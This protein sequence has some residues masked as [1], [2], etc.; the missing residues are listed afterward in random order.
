[1]RKIFMA[2]SLC[3]AF[4][5]QAQKIPDARPYAKSITSEDLKKHLYTIA[6]PDYEGRETAT[7]GQHKVA[8]YI[9]NHFKSLGLQPGNGDPTPR[10]RFWSVT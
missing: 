6:G 4:A 2:A 5:A 9:E 3:F 1:M 8:D 10:T 7:P